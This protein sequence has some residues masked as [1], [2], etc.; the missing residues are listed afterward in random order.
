MNNLEANAELML[1]FPQIM[2]RTAPV[3][4][5]HS[6]PRTSSTW[7]WAKF[8]ELASTLCFYEPFNEGNTWL[9]RER[10]ARMNH[11]SWHSRHSPTDP[12][13]REYAPLVRET[14][15]VQ[16]FD[17]AMTIQWF[18][19][20]GGLRGE[21]RPSEKEYLSLLIRQAD[22]VGKIPVIGG[23]RSLG[24]SWAIKKAFGGFNIFQYR[25]LWQQW[26]SFLSYKRRGDMVF[27]VTVM[28][29][30][31]REDDPYFA[32]LVKQGLKH[33]AEPWAGKDQTW[34][35]GL[36]WTRRYVNVPR[37]EEKVRQLELMPEH[38]AFVI[39]M[40]LHIYLYL[41][42]QL[43]A[44]LT[45][46]VTRM[47]R[48][49]G[50]RSDIEQAARRYTGLAV[51]FSDIA[52]TERLNGIDFDV[53][54]IDWDEIRE[55]ARVAVQMLSTFADPAQLMANATAF[56]ESTIDEM[57]K[58]GA[59]LTL[60]SGAAPISEVEAKQPVPDQGQTT[61]T[62]RRD[63]GM[64]TIGLCMI[65][66]NEAKVIR[67]CL[68][69]VRPLL[70]Y[71][72]VEDTGSTDG[73]QNIIRDWLTQTGLAGEVFDEPWQDFAHNR[74]VALARLR[75]N[76]A[77]DYALIMDADD[78]MEYEPDFDPDRFKDGLSAD[79][80]HVAIRL[81]GTK[82]ARPQIC[83]NHKAY[84]YRGVL[85]E[86]IEGPEEPLTSDTAQGLLIVAGVEGAR[87]ND[88]EKYRRDA[89][90]LEQA[91]QTE[92]DAFMRSRYTFYLA[93][94][95]RDAGDTEKAV[96]QYLLRADLGF[97]DEEIYVSL[98]QAAR[99][100]A[101]AKRSVDEVLATYQ[102][103]IEALPRRAEA[104]HGASHYCRLIGR[105]EEG[106]QI[107]ARGLALTEA[108]APA[109]L[110]IELWIY[111]YGLLDEYAINAYWSGHYRECLD[112]SLRI[113]SHPNCPESQRQRIL[114]NAKFA[115]GNLPPPHAPNL[116]SLGKESFVKQHML[117]PP[118]LLRSQLVES[119][120]V[121]VAILAKQKEPSLP[122]YLE[123]IEALDYPKSSI[124]LYIR[125][126]NNTDGTERI[127]REWVARVGHLYAGVEFDAEDV[128]TRV[129]QFGVHEWNATRFSVLGRIR[130]ISL[131]RALEQ[132]CDFYFVSDVD[133]FVRPCTL[134]ELM[135]LNLPIVA[136]LLRAI[137][138]GGFYSNYHAE[139]DTNGY[140]KECDQYHWVLNRWIRGVLEM[141]VVH[142]TYLIR[143]DV[144]NDLTYEDATSR[145]EYVVFSDSA[146]KSG[147]PQYLDNRQIYGYI[148]FDEGD[149]HHVAGGIEQART[150]LDADLSACASIED[151]TRDSKPTFISPAAGPQPDRTGTHTKRP[152]TLIFCTSFAKT[153]EEWDGR[154]RRWLQAIRSSQLVYDNLL[155]VDDGSP[156]LPDWTGVTISTDAIDET[157]PAELLLY[158]FRENLGRNNVFDFPGWYRSFTF[159]GRYAHVHGFE[160]VIHIESD[161]FLIGSRIQRYFNEAT[162]GWT[163]LWCPLWVGYPES[164][165]QVIAGDSIRKFAELHR[166]HPHEQLVGQEFECQLPFDWVEKR[167]NGNRYGEY[168]P[169]VPG[170]AEYAVQVRSGQTDDYYWW[171]KSEEVHRVNPSR[172]IE[173]TAT[174]W[175]LEPETS[176]TS[177]AVRDLKLIERQREEAAGTLAMS[178]DNQARS[179]P[180]HRDNR[181]EDAA[182]P[183]ASG[184]Q[185][186]RF[187]RLKE[188]PPSS[189][190]SNTP[191]DSYIAARDSSLI[192]QAYK[193]TTDQDGF[194]LPRS[195]GRAHARKIVI[196]GD[197]V[198][199]SMYIEPERRFCSRL[200]DILCDELGLDVTV[201][202]GG[203]GGA[204]SLH[205]FNV[206]LNKLIQVRPAAV[207]LMTGI[208]DVDVAHLKASYW[209]HDC[210]LEPIIDITT[211]NTWRDN[212]SLPYP[213]FDDRTKILTL[214]ATASELFDIPLWYATIPHRQVFSGEYVQKAFSNK[215]DFDRQVHLRK[216]MNHVTRRFA[217]NAEKPLFDLELE[218]GARSD[219]FHDM[220]H[221]NSL[222]SEAVAR[223]L[224]KCG[225]GDLLSVRK[226]L[227][228]EDLPTVSG[229][230]TSVDSQV[231]QLPERRE[232]RVADAGKP[233]VFEPQQ[234]RLV[235][236]DPAPVSSS[237]VPASLP[238]PPSS[239]GPQGD[240]PGIPEG[241]VAA[242]KDELLHKIWRGLDPFAHHPK[243][244]YEHD[245]QGW[246]SAHPY[247]TEAIDEIRPGVVVEIGVW[248]G[249]SA[250]TMARKLKEL[251][252]DGVVIAID[253]WLGAWDHWTSDWFEYLSFD[254]GFPAIYHKFIENVMHDDL[255]DVIIPLPLDSVN[256]ARVLK[257]HG[258]RP[259]IVHI[260][261]GHDYT[262]VSADL[263]E[264]W[265]VLK[266]NGIIIGDD[267]YTNGTWPEVKAAFDDFFRARGMVHIESMDGKCRI[268]KT[269][270]NA[271][272]QH[273]PAVVE[274]DQ[275]T[276]KRNAASRESVAMLKEIHLINLDRS[277]D[278]LARFKERNFHLENILRVPAIDGVLV[279]REELVQDGTITEDL[280]YIPGALG[281][282]L[283]HVGLWKKAASQNRIVTI[284]EDDVIC[285]YNF[286]DES[287]RVLSNLPADW[288]IIQWGFVFD[289][290][291]LWVD[292]GFSKAELRFYDRRFSRDY[293]RFQS[294]IHSSAA[295]RLVHSF[296]AEA[297]S[298]SPKGARALLECCL[299]LR[300]QLVSFPGTGIVT[301]D[302]G[303]D[304]AMC[305]AYG[306][307][308]AFICIPPLAIQDDTQTSDQVAIDR[309]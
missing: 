144:L 187:I 70:D 62:Q 52:D 158:H 250:M 309:G 231:W 145:H 247:L 103:A 68:D 84:R 39:F 60:P 245:T 269:P 31:F 6:A 188:F 9:T 190:I 140:Y 265:G 186:K 193:I 71:V 263:N 181:V 38:R 283:S 172:P 262:A 205:S 2:Q 217:I 164:A 286:L 18:I 99:L 223:G 168:L 101:H 296:G 154:Y 29:T 260:D 241:A 3:V 72:L 28:D 25:N 160:K 213:S 285:S 135:A 8:R 48:D 56:I 252:L 111:E 253:T 180:E 92:T 137:S 226:T 90:V 273:P 255:R 175:R 281:C 113:L 199:E 192:R 102:R 163:A 148:T 272:I 228:G 119:P 308:Q 93:Q 143:A 185:G 295:V 182:K 249:T 107:A 258:I 291:F 5:I 132:D 220:F 105:N 129:E 267:Y 254:K 299:P 274:T 7:F 67:R 32:Y 171:L 284:F 133:N 128:A 156:V 35:P 183:A 173:T 121:L 279:N 212:D 114:A 97:W 207:I 26:M 169:F 216:L 155:I 257:H 27:Y 104:I 215:A 30:I 69:S 292:F 165:I 225:I 83:S 208:V 161:S 17:P 126:N 306:S 303:I 23:W 278:R 189:E 10:A 12:Y 178:S 184:S 174:H 300:K 75:E 100:Q 106:Y 162:S 248:K 108:P 271:V 243:N 151:Q 270:A 46:D 110:F 63:A 50:Y 47:A 218:L 304:V 33:A 78:I 294:G 91:L 194:I 224:V 112:A 58:T 96:E 305:A 53:A 89:A 136:P 40:G 214:F 98:Y 124:V 85:H 152:K 204:T 191:T 288:D 236:L 244:L 277:T 77:I 109:G 73:T 206:F 79:H 234:I 198:V 201:L 125:T 195:G 76:S 88:P 266:H 20:L 222:G 276:P 66:K 239:N 36:T 87:S 34:P 219:I 232:N 117:V 139:I 177:R 307:M 176:V 13:Y 282:A 54:E 268:R 200:E 301:P 261:G 81:G 259:D 123:C 197:S 141:P 157:L 94:S 65:V 264:W 235:S 59:L 122:L 166:T 202:N 115:A 21:L 134:R 1:P 280:P 37:D 230:A 242:I 80:Y 246:N 41:H 4:F 289:P 24:R 142:C 240:I 61:A 149:D 170:N 229:L 203:Y 64:K 238:D 147:V 82:Y 146:R 275:S 19:P 57:R 293:Q 302:T 227:G 179:L 290:T 86:F 211:T 298:V 43:S 42:A 45:V 256:A 16:L 14:G 233:V 55:H 196:I 209:N 251:R 138:P 210:W 159:A 15:G 74:T 297:Y 130:N 131:R 237:T 95:C 287:A 118:R 11:D 44:D 22:E 167:F 120:R 153:Q 221:L 150:L 51:S 49:N 127:L 116:G